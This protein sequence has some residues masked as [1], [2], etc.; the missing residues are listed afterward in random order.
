VATIPI[1]NPLPLR[2]W[3]S[4][5]GNASCFHKRFGDASVAHYTKAV[6]L[7]VELRETFLLKQQ[8]K[9]KQYRRDFSHS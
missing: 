3:M 8:N 5:F 1:F 4:N 9:K 7:F 2:L 6:Q